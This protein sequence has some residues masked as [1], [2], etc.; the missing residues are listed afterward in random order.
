MITGEDINRCIEE[1][2]GLKLVVVDTGRFFKFEI[3]VGQDA[4]EFV[5]SAECL[6]KCAARILNQTTDLI[7]IRECT[8][9]DE[10]NGYW[11]DP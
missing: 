8:Q 5:N 7:I 6:A 1:K 2:Q 11:I 9:F 3:P 10:V 4:E